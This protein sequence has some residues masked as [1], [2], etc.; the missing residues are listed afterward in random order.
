[1]T[2]KKTIHKDTFFWWRESSVKGTLVYELMIPEHAMPICSVW[3]RWVGKATIEV[4]QSF[5]IE[6]FRRRGYRT[7]LHNEIAK[8]NH[9]AKWM[10]TAG[11]NKD[12]KAWLKKMGFWKDE[13]TGDW[14][15]EINRDGRIRKK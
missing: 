7:H 13:I 9:Q 15:L 12:G 10:M 8:L 4:L 1:M 5:T 11:G 2:K 3:A 6:R 14:M